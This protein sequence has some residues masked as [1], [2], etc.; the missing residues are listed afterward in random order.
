MKYIAIL[1]FAILAFAATAVRA[2]AQTPCAQIQT[3]L[4]GSGHMFGADEDA[5][6]QTADLS[7]LQKTLAAT[8]ADEASARKELAAA[9]ADGDKNLASI[10]RDVVSDLDR[11]IRQTKQS[12]ADATASAAAAKQQQQ[13]LQHQSVAHGCSGSTVSTAATSP[14]SA[15]HDY[16]GQW[17]IR[18][19]AIVF[20]QP[21]TTYHNANFSGPPAGP[22]T[23]DETFVATTIKEFQGS[24]GTH[25]TNCIVSLQPDGSPNFSCHATNGWLTCP[26]K[27]QSDGSFTGRCQNG[28]AVRITR[29]SYSPP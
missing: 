27:A 16:S 6:T 14:G 19:D 13:M 20:G 10:E 18:T 9:V 26:L 5:G 29:G 21:A 2:Q 17:V 22:W 1:T 28:S 23:V 12:I 8:Q 7:E 11:T 3:L 4:A 25:D 24:V 15:S